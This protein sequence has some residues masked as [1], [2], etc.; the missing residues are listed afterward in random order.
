MG[1]EGSVRDYI[2]PDDCPWSHER[3][4]NFTEFTY[5]FKP[6]QVFKMD[7]CTMCV[8]ILLLWALIAKARNLKLSIAVDAMPIDYL[9]LDDYKF[10]KPLLEAE[11]AYPE[12]GTLADYTGSDV[13]VDEYPDAGCEKSLID[14]PP[15]V[16]TN[17][18]SVT[19]RDILT[20]SQCPASEFL[21]LSNLPPLVNMDELI[22]HV[23]IM[24]GEIDIQKSQMIFDSN[25]VYTRSI[26]FSFKH[27]PDAL[28]AFHLYN[29]KL[30]DGYQMCAVYYTNVQHKT[31]LDLNVLLVPPSGSESSPCPN[32]IDS[33]LPTE[34]TTD[35]CELAI[36]LNLEIGEML[37]NQ[38][39]VSVPSYTP[40][41]ADDR[42]LD[43]YEVS[44]LTSLPPD[45]DDGLLDDYETSPVTSLPALLD[46]QLVSSPAAAVPEPKI[47]LA[48]QLKESRDAVKKLSHRIEDY[49]NRILELE[50]EL[51]ASRDSA[52]VL[53]TQYAG[54]QTWISEK[55]SVETQTDST[56]QL[57]AP[58]DVGVDPSPADGI[59]S[60]DLQCKM[61]GMIETTATECADGFGFELDLDVV[62]DYSNQS[63]PYNIPEWDPLPVVLPERD[64]LLEDDL[65]QLVN[66]LKNPPDVEA[67]AQQ[68]TTACQSSW[69]DE[70]VDQDLPPE[71]VNMPSAPSVCSM[72]QAQTFAYTDFRYRDKPIEGYAVFPTTEDEKSAEHKTS[73]RIDLKD[74]FPV[75]APGPKT[76]APP[77]RMETFRIRNNVVHTKRGYKDIIANIGTENCG[78]ILGKGRRNIEDLRKRFGVGINLSQPDEEGLV[79]VT[80]TGGTADD[81]NAA[82]QEL[83]DQLPVKVDVTFAFGSLSQVERNLSGQS[84]PFVRITYDKKICGYVFSGKLKECREAFEKLKVQV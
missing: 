23:E 61:T 9:K 83:V 8:V 32:Y 45:A 84:F 37:S 74:I 49:E 25:N 56:T 42:F 57:P 43:D 35:E 26:V 3:F 71:E 14:I 66:T 77:K 19:G 68:Q 73:I 27:A 1:L 75:S 24:I 69:V 4:A 21:Y 22:D 80:V 44:L 34:S 16:D 64:Q 47:D 65:P 54:T 15:Y 10:R 60:S 2:R 41:D 78:R 46:D 18:F 53:V 79:I 28:R 29:G 70:P 5:F 20:T 40:P 51:K 6:L 31:S 39:F 30:F 81:R 17:D 62:D 12:S 72:S 7:F 50:L 63:F 55:K 52:S 76:N 67:P 36:E 33:G 11:L 82:V 38:P 13:T 59:P 48:L 58:V